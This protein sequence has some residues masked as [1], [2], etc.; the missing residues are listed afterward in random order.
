MAKAK[1]NRTLKHTFSILYSFSLNEE[2]LITRNFA[3]IEQNTPLL[4]TKSVYG[5]RLESIV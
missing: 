2:V 5:S 3:S 4:K 1:I